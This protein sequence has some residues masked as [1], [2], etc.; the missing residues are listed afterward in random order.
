[1]CNVN[2]KSPTLSHRRGGNSATPSNH[3]QEEVTAWN[4]SRSNVGWLVVLGLTAI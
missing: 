2:Q 1:M 4:H 3:E